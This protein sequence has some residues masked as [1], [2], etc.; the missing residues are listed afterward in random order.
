MFVEEQAN[1]GKLQQTYLRDQSKF[2]DQEMERN[3]LEFM[4]A[5][6][7]DFKKQAEDKLR[8]M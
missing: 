1:Y 7:Q 3:E 2:E 6:L 8:T 5:K 4:V